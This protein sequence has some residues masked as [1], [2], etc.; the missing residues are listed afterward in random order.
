M[1]TIYG[2]SDDLIEIE[3]DIREE[4]NIYNTDGYLLTST[5]VMIKVRYDGEWFFNVVKEG[6]NTYVRVKPIEEG[7]Y[8]ETV[9]ID[10]PDVKWIAFTEKS[11]VAF[12]S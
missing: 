8:T 7:K 3:G 11:F 5:G 12:G 10:S 2:H 6:K 1:I 9:L 4:F